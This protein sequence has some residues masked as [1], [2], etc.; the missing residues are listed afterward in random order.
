MTTAVSA[1]SDDEL[2]LGSSSGSRTA[3]EALYERHHRGVYDL[4]CRMLRDEDAAADVVQTTFTNAWVNLQK[5]RVSGNVRAWLYAIARN[6][7]INELRR[8]RRRVPLDESIDSQRVPYADL[9]R[10]RMPDPEQALLDNEVAQ[11]VWDSAA[12][13][14]P[15]EY[16]LL[17]LH[18]RRGFTAEE[19]AG[20]LGMTRGNVHTMLFRLRRSLEESVT[21]LLLARRGRD[22]CPELDALL[23]NRDSAILTVETRRLIA[24]HLEGCARCQESR[25]RFVSPAEIFAGLALIPMPETSRIAIWQAIAGAV[26]AGGAGLGLVTHGAQEG[27][28][29][30]LQGLRNVYAIA[31]GS[32]AVAVVVIVAAILLSSGGGVEDPSDVRSSTHEIGVPSTER[33]V[34]V[35]WTPQ[36]VDGYSVS[37]SRAEEALPDTLRDLPGDASRAQSAALADGSWY[38][39]LRTEDGGK[40]TSTVHLGPFVIRGKPA[41]TPAPSPTPRVERPSPSPAV[42]A[43]AQAPAG[44]APAGTPTAAPVTAPPPAVVAPAPAPT[45]VPAPAPTPSPVPQPV[46]LTAIIDIKPG[47]G[48]NSVNS[49]GRQVIGVALISTESLSATQVNVATVLFAGAPAIRSAMRDVNA[50]GTADLVMHFE[51]EAT[52]LNG[53]GSAACLEGQT[54]QGARFFGCDSIKSLGPGIVLAGAGGGTAT[55]LLL[56]V[57]V[58]MAALATLRRVV[59]SG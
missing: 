12:A 21:G 11:L 13:L 25:R 35:T 22:D 50:D 24:N 14:N 59:A 42:A 15:R 54:L 29:W 26:A 44:Q 32:A 28:R 36:D 47:E 1:V 19:M 2:A 4:A 46:V 38:F 9:D 45:S 7:A 27:V 48:E 31:A 51:S 58:L 53:Q 41:A 10:D 43:A 40:W 8:G 16:S 39:H 30:L 20:S 6:A 34:V 5:R 17:D 18:L 52:S 56:M 37:W 23:A 49:N 55:R 3:F 57:P 33:V